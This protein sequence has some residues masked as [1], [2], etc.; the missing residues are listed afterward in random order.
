MP[1]TREPQQAKSSPLTQPVSFDCVDLP[2]RGKTDNLFVRLLS[3]RFN[4][5]I[6]DR[7]DFLVFTHDGDRH[8]LYNC[9][10]IFYTQEV[11][12]PNWRECD[13]AVTSVK[14][15]DPRAF[16]LPVYS[17]W[18]D[19]ADLIRPAD[20]D[21]RA[22]ARQKTEFCGFLTGYVDRSVQVRT[23]FFRKLNAL[24]KVNSAGTA[25]NNVGYGVRGTIERRDWLRR[26]KFYMAFENAAIPGWTTE[27]II[28][29]FASFT[30]PIYWG[31]PT[32]ASQFNPAAFIHRRDF[33]SDESCIRHV[34][35]VDADETLYLRYLSAPP[36]LDNRLNKE[37]DHERLLDFSGGSSPSQSR[38]WPGADGSGT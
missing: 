13:Y 27:R 2:D 6:S 23:G 5:K 21:Y 18:C 29:A 33:D 35:E 32:I 9:T 1:E 31:D 20:A 7:P 38:P 11:Y 30:V 8:R 22:L 34:L 14:L 10:K 25:L 4:L 16:H 24:K 12:R 26:H 36:F 17:L 15:E 3:R 37:W 19:A 28:D